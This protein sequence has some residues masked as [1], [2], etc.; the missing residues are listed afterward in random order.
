MQRLLFTAAPHRL[1]GGDGFGRGTNF[2][3]IAVKTETDRDPVP[4]I[5]DVDHQRELDLLFIGEVRDQGIVRARVSHD[6]R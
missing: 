4:A 5:D 2:G 1:L 6:L 3:R